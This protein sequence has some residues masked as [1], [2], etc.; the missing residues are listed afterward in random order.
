MDC[1]D[2]CRKVCWKIEVI[3]VSVGL[4]MVFAGWWINKR[5]GETSFAIDI[6]ASF[7]SHFNNGLYGR[8]NRFIYFF[9]SSVTIF[10]PNS[11]HIKCATILYAVCIIAA[12]AIAIS[13]AMHVTMCIRCLMCFKLANLISSKVKRK[14]CTSNFECVAEKKSLK[15]RIMARNFRRIL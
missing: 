13:L 2:V 6:R 11:V 15:M 10:G 1:T 7:V 3:L 8:W 12:A 4:C 9:C 14:H 5:A